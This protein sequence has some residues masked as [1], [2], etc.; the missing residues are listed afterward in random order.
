MREM[1]GFQIGR[2]QTSVLLAAHPPVRTPITTVGEIL[3]FAND[4]QQRGPVVGV[5]RPPRQGMSTVA[6]RWFSHLRKMKRPSKNTLDSCGGIRISQAR[7]QIPNP[8]RPWS[9]LR[10]SASA[11]A[12]SPRQIATL[13]GS[14]ADHIPKYHQQKISRSPGLFGKV[15]H[16]YL[17][18]S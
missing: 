17:R 7:S 4:G 18:I 10:R 6:L 1:V 8:S 16:Q 2:L 9:R 5:Y 3:C 14:V 15:T 11:V 12:V 13:P